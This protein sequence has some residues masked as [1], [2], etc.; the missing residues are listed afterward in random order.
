[1]RRAAHRAD[2]R[3]LVGVA[4]RAEADDADHGFVAVQLIGGRCAQFGLR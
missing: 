4:R 3:A 2:A 1:M